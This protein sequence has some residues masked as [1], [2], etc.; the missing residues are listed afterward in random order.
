[1]FVLGHNELSIVVSKTLSTYQIVAALVFVI[2]FWHSMSQIWHRK[3]CFLVSEATISSTRNTCLSIRNAS[4]LIW[5]TISFALN[6]IQAF[7]N[8]ILGIQN[9]FALIEIGDI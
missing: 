5:E 4:P 8:L 2:W 3:Q 7:E 6:T 9:E 1:M